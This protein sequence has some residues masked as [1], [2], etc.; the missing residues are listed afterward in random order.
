MIENGL[1]II[2]NRWPLLTEIPSELKIVESFEIRWSLEVE[3]VEQGVESTKL[4]RALEDVALRMFHTVLLR[5]VLSKSDFTGADLESL[6]LVDVEELH[7]TLSAGDVFE[8]SMMLHGTSNRIRYPLEVLGVVL[9][10]IFCA[11]VA[12]NNS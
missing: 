3:Q 8:R 12:D 4:I 2:T 7:Q 11:Q 5:E 6:I 1:D 10:L 9:S